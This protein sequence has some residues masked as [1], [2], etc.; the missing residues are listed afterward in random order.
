MRV[1]RSISGVVLFALMLT[2]CERAPR[3]DIL[4]GFAQGTTWHVSGWRPG[5]VDLS[6]IAQG[7]S[8]ERIAA[9]VEAA[10]IGNYIV[11]IGGEMQT[12]GH[13]P[14]G[15]HWRIGVERPLPGQRSVDKG[16]TIKRDA[17]MA[18]MTSGTYRHYFDDHGKRYSHILDARSGKPMAHD[19]VSVTVLD[20]NP[21]YADAWCTALLCLGADDG[22][23]AAD[24]AGIAALFIS[25]TNGQL[26]ERASA[27]WS[28]LNDVE[29]E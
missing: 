21:T 25:D 23:R 9:V 12:R 15:S 22:L 8:V 5:G 13:K 17:P 14:D 26:R 18:V 24:Q 3:V 2:G 20:E 28:A 11:E 6:S 19:T 29:V 4:S 10:G 7:Y 1:M 27:A 16:L